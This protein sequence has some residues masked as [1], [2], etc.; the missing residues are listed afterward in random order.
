MEKLTVQTGSEW[1]ACINNNA[2]A[3]ERTGFYGLELPG[4]ASWRKGH[5]TE[6]GEVMKNV[7]INQAS[8][9]TNTK[10]ESAW[11]F[12]E[13]DAVKPWTFSPR[14][15]FVEREKAGWCTVVTQPSWW[16][17][18]LTLR[19]WRRTERPQGAALGDGNGE[20]SR[21]NRGWSRKTWAETVLT[22][23]VAR[24]EAMQTST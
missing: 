17:H 5:W 16:P 21:V 20:R 9:S 3:L 12:S 13:E 14:G 7:L 24:K 10:K 11:D 1:Q 19:G 2:D 8:H 23:S 15:W 4:R 22:H 18:H 6:C